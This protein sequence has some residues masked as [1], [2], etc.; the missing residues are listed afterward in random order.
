MAPGVLAS[1]AYGV[2]TTVGDMLRFVADN[3]GLVPIEG[4]LQGAITATIGGYYKVGSMTQDLI[5]EQY[6][7]PVDLEDLLAGKELSDRGPRDRRLP[8]IDAAD[9]GSTGKVKTA[10]T[11]RKWANVIEFGP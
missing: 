7:Y 5:W 1:E 6:R 9:W 10:A 2:R 4:D 8:D 3:L 11:G